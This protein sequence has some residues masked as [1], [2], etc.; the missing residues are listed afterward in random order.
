CSLSGPRRDGGQRPSCAG[1][2]SRSSSKLGSVPNNAKRNIPWSNLIGLRVEL[3]SK[4]EKNPSHWWTR[5]HWEQPGRQTHLRQRSCR[6]RRL[7]YRSAQE[8]RP[9]PEKPE[10]QAHQGQYSGSE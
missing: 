6:H 8:C 4:H 7:F 10:V 2:A 3:K 9:S 5:V 1:C